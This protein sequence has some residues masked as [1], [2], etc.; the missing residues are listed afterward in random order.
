MLEVGFWLCRGLCNRRC[1]YFESTSVLRMEE[2]ERKIYGCWIEWVTKKYHLA[3]VGQD[4]LLQVR[5]RQRKKKK[6]NAKCYS[7]Q[8]CTSGHE[9]QVDWFMQF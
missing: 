3:I 5:A 6:K 2:Y 1:D 8:T 4:E 9:T 7:P